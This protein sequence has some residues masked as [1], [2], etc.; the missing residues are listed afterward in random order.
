MKLL[1]LN[2]RWFV[3]HEGGP[4]VGFTFDC[5]HCCARRLGVGV[6]DE[7]RRIIQ[8]QEPDAHAPG[9]VWEITGGTDFHDISLT[10]SIDA[11]RWGC[12][13][14]FITNGQIV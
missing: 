14:G 4:R 10:P 6:H 12:W 11:R 3:L 13:H 2:P 7:A 8:D 9:V 5:P 1:D